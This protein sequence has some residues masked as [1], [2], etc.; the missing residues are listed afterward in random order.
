MD[1]Q[2]QQSLD[3]IREQLA[4]G[5]SEAAIRTGFAQSG[6]PQPA[7]DNL[8]TQYYAS[9]G[10]NPEATVPAQPATTT[11]P[12]TTSA[13]PVQS[14]QKPKRRLPKFFI[15]VIIGGVVLLVLILILA[16][17]LR[18]ST[19]SKVINKTSQAALT[20]NAGDVARKTD[21]AQILAGISNYVA[22]HSGNLPDQ[23]A[24][25][26]GPDTILL[27]GGRCTPAS[28]MPVSLSHY[29]NTPQAVSFHAY[30]KDLKVPDAETV[31]IV[32][33][34]SCNGDSLG[35]TNQPSRA[36]VLFASPNG[37]SLKQQCVNL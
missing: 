6:W 14:T 17:V 35:A 27:C 10:N 36:A 32:G 21:V 30:A 23:T 7:V 16:L 3:Y 1:P 31:Y 20:Q 9:Q 25:G 11:P 28:E 4:A 37:S 26:N 24:A 2:L 33:N 15:P 13:E 18:G 29:K 8:F 19:G 5:Q 34:T 22:S 12:V